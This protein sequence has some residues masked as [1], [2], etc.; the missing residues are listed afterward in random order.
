MWTSPR[1]GEARVLAAPPWTTT[2]DVLFKKSPKAVTM[3]MQKDEVL[4]LGASYHV[5][6]RPEG[7]T[8][9]MVAVVYGR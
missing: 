8:A 5:P 1:W 6:D 3:T 2:K 7:S 4:E 9:W